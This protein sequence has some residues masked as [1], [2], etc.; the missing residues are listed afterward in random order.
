MIQTKN[1]QLIT[2]E[3]S[4]LEAIL[5][6]K[7]EL[8]SILN[9]SVPD[10]WPEFP[11]SISYTYELLKSDPSLLDWWMYLFIHAK[12]KVLIGSGGFK[13][14][15]D[16]SGMVEIGYQIVPV[17]RNRGF[18]TEASRGFIDYAFSHPQVKW[19]DAHT[20]AE[21]NASTRVIEKVG[22][23]YMG[24]VH[25]PADGTIWHWRLTREDY[26]RNGSVRKYGS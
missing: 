21:R 26:E 18:A 6:N 15:P 9:I 14:R 3:L 7:K 11:E 22:M 1:L 12:D 16:R 13:G 2:C 17:Y 23:K 19:V 4:Y 10:S 8:E 5:R 24:V 20:L 25:D